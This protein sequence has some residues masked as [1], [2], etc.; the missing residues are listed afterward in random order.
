MHLYECIIIKI[1]AAVCAH[2]RACVWHQKY[3]H[4]CFRVQ[5]PVPQ[6]VNISMCIENYSQFNQTASNMAQQ[7]LQLRSTNYQYNV[8]VWSPPPL[9]PRAQNSI[10]VM[11]FSKSA[12]NHQERPVSSCTRFS[13]SSDAQKNK[14]TV[15][16]VNHRD[17]YLVK[18]INVAQKENSTFFPSNKSYK[19]L[20]SLSI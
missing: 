11:T 17:D 2:A 8:K 3:M 7:P 9:P 15:L 1:N 10:L 14:V 4:A 6:K 18:E 12:I 19:Y 5:N 16:D 20:W 13:F